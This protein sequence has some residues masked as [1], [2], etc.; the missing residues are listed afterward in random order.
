MSNLCL[1]FEFCRK[2][3]QLNVCVRITKICFEF[4]CLLNLFIICNLEK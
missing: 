1:E 4:Y 2:S 3:D